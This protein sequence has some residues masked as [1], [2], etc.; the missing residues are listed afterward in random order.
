MYEKR[1]SITSYQGNANQNHSALSRGTCQ[2]GCHQ[3]DSKQG[4]SPRR[5]GR[6]TPRALPV[7][8]GIGATTVE[9]SVEDPP[10]IRNGPAL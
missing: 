6:G 2:T 3:K 5:W 7:G 1:L 8:M 10:K 9:S 4:V